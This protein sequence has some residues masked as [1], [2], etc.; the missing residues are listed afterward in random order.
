MMKN[1]ENISHVILDD[2]EKALL[3]SFENGEWERIKNFEQEKKLAQNAA[4]N[5]LRKD[6]RINIR[7][8]S[9]DLIRIKHKAAYE[10]LPYQ[11]LIAS[12]IHKYSAGHS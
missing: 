10:R 3:E 11:T 9:S 1:K 5:Y 7:I 8:S 6:I 12:I 4:A 2:E